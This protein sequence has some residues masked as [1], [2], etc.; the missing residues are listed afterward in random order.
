MNQLNSRERT[1][2]F[3]ILGIGLV[4]LMYYGWTS[5]QSARAQ[6][7]AA[8]DRA[9]I[10]TSELETLAFEADFELDRVAVYNE[11]SLPM[12]AAE[13]TADYQNFIWNLALRAG[14]ET[15]VGLAK[16]EEVELGLSGVGMAA[17]RVSSAADPKEV[18][19]RRVRLTDVTLKGNLQQLTNFLFSFYDI[20]LLHRLDSLSVSLEAPDKEDETR[21]VAKMS[22]SAAV[23]PGAPEEKA[24]DEYPRGRLGKSLDE[25]RHWIVGRN[26]FGPPNVAPRI[27]AR[28]FEV[29]VN[30][31]PS[32]RVVATDGNDDD[33]LTF[34]LLESSLP[35]ATLEQASPD[36]RQATL[37]APRVTSPGRHTFR[38][39][40]SDNR[41]PQLSDEQLVTLTVKEPRPPRQQERAIVAPPP[42]FRP[43]TYITS[44][45]QDRN[46]VAEV[47]INIRPTDEILRLKEGES[48]ELDREK[49]VVVKVDPRTVTFKRGD[50]FLVFRIG[51]PLS[52]PISTSKA[53]TRA[54]SIPR[55]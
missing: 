31:S 38:I 19:Y 11:A 30:D 49:W 42:K 14:L 40:V 26:L 37:K 21:L 9:E 20:G 4:F 3:A 41:I 44:L 50:E 35:N 29:E 23:L 1:L 33:L 7:I 52:D 2:L 25:F 28:S 32:H 27:T 22:I 55:D 16:L 51:S 12:A 34:E 53:V 18:V 17:G 24:W 5:F 46:G 54:D 8:K 36:A 48:F 10:R 39:R 15:N 13:N 6:R 47:V 43:D 45:L